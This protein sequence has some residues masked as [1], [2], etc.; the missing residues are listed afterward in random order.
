MSTSSVEKA[1]SYRK[2]GMIM[3]LVLAILVLA[4]FYYGGGWIF[5]PYGSWS[6]KVSLFLVASIFMVGLL[7]AIGIYVTKGGSSAAT[8][9]RS[10]RMAT[11]CFVGSSMIGSLL[12]VFTT[13]INPVDTAA[14]GLYGAMLVLLAFGVL[15][16]GIYSMRI[17]RGFSH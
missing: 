7:V 9:Q 3:P 5:E 13:S 12:L 8:S 17:L 11:L 15:S 1:V 2:H 10:L 16:L 4:G 6:M 14:Y